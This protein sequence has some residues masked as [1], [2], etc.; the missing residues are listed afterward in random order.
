MKVFV[1][2]MMSAVVLMAGAAHG[3]SLPPT[4][5]VPTVVRVSD[6]G[7][8]Y[9]AMP[10]EYPPPVR[11]YDEA[12]PPSRAYGALRYGYSLAVLPL[13]EVY[14]IVREAGFSLLGMPQQRGP[15]YTVAA[16]DQDGEDGRLVIDA[17]SGQILRFMPAYGLRDRPRPELY[18]RDEPPAAPP[19]LPQYRRPPYAETAP[20]PAAGPRVASRTPAVPLPKKAPVR[21]VAAPAK[22]VATE[23]AKPVAVAPPATPPAAAPVQQSAVTEP[24]AIEAKPAETTGA[25]APAAAPAASKP[26]AAPTVAT[27]L[28]EAKPAAPEKTDTPPVQGLE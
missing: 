8:P 28:V 7:G 15:V 9:A 4:A 3:Q 17:R 1:G 25:A 10:P 12:P 14:A 2:S 24:K 23:A 5:D 13:R 21:A 19:M 26:E 18:V 27:P 22:P 11:V 20:G 6:V 16:V